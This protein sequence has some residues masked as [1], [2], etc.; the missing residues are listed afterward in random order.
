[1]LT[2][3]TNAMPPIAELPDWHFWS[4]DLIAAAS[5]EEIEQMKRGELPL[6][7]IKQLAKAGEEARQ[8]LAAMPV[9]GFQE[10]MST[11]R[12]MN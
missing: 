1:M 8:A 3:N 12:G 5:P 6:E 9:P 4:R 10:W 7:R 2:L 11:R